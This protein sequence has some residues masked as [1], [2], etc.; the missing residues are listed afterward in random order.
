MYVHMYSSEI[1]HICPSDFFFFSNKESVKKCLWYFMVWKICV[2][3]YDI[4]LWMCSCWTV[5]CFH[6][7][8]AA[9][10]SLNAKHWMTGIR[11]LALQKMIMISIVDRPVTEWK[12]K[13]YYN[14]IA[15]F[16]KKQGC[17]VGHNRVKC[18]S[19][20]SNWLYKLYF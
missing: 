10:W 14:V 1:L 4:L 12:D 6:F 8:N 3:Y 16:I 17:S 11:T 7:Y 2:I 9:V 18:L 20:R 5:L 19:N 13:K 15:V